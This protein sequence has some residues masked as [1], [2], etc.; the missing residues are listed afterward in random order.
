MLFCKA[1]ISYTRYLEKKARNDRQNAEAL[2]RSTLPTPMNLGA[3]A[4]IGFP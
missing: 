2:K 4:Q 3:E 1:F